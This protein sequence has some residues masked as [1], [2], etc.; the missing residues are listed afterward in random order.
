MMLCCNYVSKVKRVI[1]V[2]QRMD[3]RV[4]ANI[5]RKPLKAM[6]EDS[7]Y[8]D[9]SLLYKYWLNISSIKYNIHCHR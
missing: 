7:I 9:K 6:Y 2:Y 3:Q 1:I 4:I 5:P 8:I